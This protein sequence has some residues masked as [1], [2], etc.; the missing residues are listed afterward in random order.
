VVTLNGDREHADAGYSKADAESWTDVLRDELGITG[1]EV[2]D[3]LPG[4]QARFPVGGK[5]W[6]SQRVH[7]RP[8]QAGTVTEGEPESY[9]RWPERGPSPWFLSGDGASVHVLLDDG[10]ESWWPARWL[11]T[12]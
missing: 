3:L 7:W 10:Y 9:A 5:V 12:R 2:R 1:A 11:E 6:L 4:L 8:G